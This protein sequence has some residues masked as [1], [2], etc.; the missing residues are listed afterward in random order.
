MVKPAIR[1]LTPFSVPA[2][3]ARL[4]VKLSSASFLASPAS[5]AVKLSCAFLRVPRVLSGEAL[6][7]FSSLRTSAAPAPNA[8]SLPAATSRESGTIPQLVHG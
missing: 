1:F 5:S 7:Y 3:L 6:A 8:L 2:A 4:A